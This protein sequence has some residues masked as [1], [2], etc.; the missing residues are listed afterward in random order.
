[1]TKALNFTLDITEGGDTQV[2]IRD[3]RGKKSGIWELVGKKKLGY[4]SL[5]FGIWDIRGKKM[6]NMG[7][8]V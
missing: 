1:M 6:W 7:D 4:R 2:G 3:I 8:W 5:E